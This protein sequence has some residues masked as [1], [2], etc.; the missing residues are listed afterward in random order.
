MY[1]IYYII[2]NNI[3]YNFPQT[4]HFTRWLSYLYFSHLTYTSKLFY[5]KARRFA[6]LSLAP[7]IKE[8]H[9]PTVNAFKF[10]PEI[11]DGSG[12]RLRVLML[13]Q[14]I[15]YL[16]KIPSRNIQSL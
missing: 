10:E 1:Y 16:F 9:A 7:V 15:F 12:K 11:T 5:I 3:L 8:N 14:S 2:F 4:F 6:A 13:S